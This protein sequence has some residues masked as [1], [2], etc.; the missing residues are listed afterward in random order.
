[1]R[2]VTI[3]GPQTNLRAVARL[4][5]L[6]ASA[7]VGGFAFVITAALGLMHGGY[8]STAWGWGSLACLWLAVMAL[9]FSDRLSL[10]PPELA[11]VCALNAFL[12][13]TFLS[14]AWS[15]A[16]PAAIREVERGV[17]V[18]SAVIAAMLLA[19][20]HM[21]PVLG[22]VLGGIFVVCSYGLATRLF[23]SR[24]GRFDA[25]AGYRLAD[26]LGY[27]NALGLLAVIG[28]LL[29]IGFAARGRSVAARAVGTAA[30]IFL[31][32]T[33]YFTFGRGA[34][35]ALAIGMGAAIGLDRKRLQLI[36]TML[37]IAPFVALALWL[38]TREPDLNRRAA[39]LAGAT[40]EGRRL[41]L[42]LVGLGAVAAV[43][44]PVLQFAERR[45]VVNLRIR[46]AYGSAIVALFIGLIGL[47]IAHYGSPQHIANRVYDAFKAP[48]LKVSSSGNLNQRLFS[49][50]GSGRLT[51]WRVALDDY[52]AHPWLGSG[53]GT[54]EL[55]W[56]KERPTGT[57]KIRDA[58]N[59]YVEVLAELGPVGLALLLFA[60]AIPVYA[61]VKARRHP[62]VP[63]ALGA[64]LAFLLH[65]A[66]DWDWEMPAVAIA[67]LLCGVAILVVA[68]PNLESRLL[69]RRV[70]IGA[71]TGL[72][73]IGGFVF[74]AL[75]GNL[76]LAASNGS[77]DRLKWQD[78]AKQ[79]RRA[80]HWLPWS[81][82]PWRQLAEAQY[83][84]G[85]FSAAQANFRNA[86]AKDPNNWLLWAELGVS[87]EGTARRAAIEHAIR[88]NPLAPELADYRKDYGK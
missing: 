54:Y 80:A 73:A 86:I 78:S 64:Y 37:A 66:A 70:R 47:G 18:L 13:W 71:V 53:A 28:I 38:C 44:G 75:I 36:S 23:P 29:S 88:L 22:G 50:S 31:F 83:A 46:V 20:R 63:L 17:L 76:A 15:V 6:G 35:A 57:W 34:W 62:L 52:R 27:W 79:A 10:G 21:R 48:P 51:Q 2:A 33:M 7:R 65:A 61:A 12:L 55:S 40:S 9:L 25:I 69:T 41:A 5:L 39:A 74:V 72:V 11:S 56:L 24:L 42:M 87:S 84:Q 14:S 8:F 67:G 81:S 85:H 16:P 77:A 19:R 82:D 45:L 49:L 68:R 3:D 4:S 58:H 26:P 32:P 60:F 30:P 43:V 59:L 1:M